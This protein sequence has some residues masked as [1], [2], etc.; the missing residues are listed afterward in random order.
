MHSPEVPEEPKAVH[1][2]HF[3][4]ADLPVECFI[5]VEIDFARPEMFESLYLPWQHLMHL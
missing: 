3:A 4:S 1:P 2:V 5:G